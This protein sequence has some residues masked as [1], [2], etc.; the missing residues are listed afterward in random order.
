MPSAAQASQSLASAHA[1]PLVSH[2]LPTSHTGKNKLPPVDEQW[3]STV[4]ESLVSSFT[5]TAVTTV[6]THKGLVLQEA[7]AA[8]KAG[9]HK[10][11]Y[12]AQQPTYARSASEGTRSSASTQLVRVKEEK[13]EEEEE[14][15]QTEHSQLTDVLT[16]EQSQIPAQNVALISSML[17]HLARAV[18]QEF[19]RMQRNQQQAQLSLNLGQR[20]THHVG[21]AMA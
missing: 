13:M 6:S 5:R 18:P 9:A 7:R 20:Q 17:Q 12:M 19:Y 21:E 16:T 10:Q 14:Q 1:P 4:I 15:T 2:A 8:E 3:M 11:G